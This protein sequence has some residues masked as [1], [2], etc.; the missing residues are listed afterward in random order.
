MSLEAQKDIV[1]PIEVSYLYASQDELLRIELE[2]HLSILQ[3]Q[4]L[5]TIWHA[6]KISPGTEWK[7]EVQKHLNTAQIILLLVSPDFI[8]S[9]YY[10]NEMQFALERHQSHEVRV[11]P[12]LLRPIDWENLPLADLQS[13]PPNLKPVTSWPGRN[14]RDKAFVEISKGVRAA[15]GA[16]FVQ[17]SLV[18]QSTPEQWIVL[19]DT[20]FQSCRYHDALEAYEKALSTN[21]Q[22]VTAYLGK[23]NVF[24]RLRRSRVDI[25]HALRAFEKAIQL[26]PQNPM[27]LLRKGEMLWSLYHYEEALQLIEQAISLEANFI[28]AYHKKAV[29]LSDSGIRN[30]DHALNHVLALCQDALQRDPNN[31]TLLW[32]QASALYS[33]ERFEES[34]DVCKQIS[35]LDADFLRGYPLQAI[36]YGQ[37][38]QYTEALTWADL[39]IQRDPEIFVHYNRKGRLLMELNQYDEALI[40]YE[41][42]IRLAPDN[43]VAYVAKGEIL[44]RKEFLLYKAA[45]QSF[46]NNPE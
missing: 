33:F 29:L 34:L 18:P 27:I 12:I 15:V 31:V 42:A 25:E 23:G 39:L 21:P 37:M 5:I 38:K 1:Q 14:G 24:A 36:L 16:L 45:L 13:L 2:K 43:G 10:S 41:E 19:G 3:Q 26:D 22:A 30:A 20:Y 46:A 44:K 4:N 8:A 28:E 17:K 7:E 6:H 9:E 40:C 32:Y 11:I 35:Q